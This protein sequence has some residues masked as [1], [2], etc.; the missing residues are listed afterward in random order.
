M[1]SGRFP[2]SPSAAAGPHLRASGTAN[3]APKCG[4]PTAGSALRRI[5]TR[6]ETPASGRPCSRSTRTR[7]L[8][9]APEVFDVVV[10]VDAFPYSGRDDPC[11]RY[12]A[13][14][15]K[16]GGVLGIAGA[17]LMQEIEGPVP[18]HLRDRCEP[19]LWCLSS[20]VWWRRHWKR[21][22]FV[23]TGDI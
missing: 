11:L 16:S 23:E 10:S 17:G 12:A 1:N 19:G 21:T 6:F 3:S 14:F 8:P 22:G 7:A 2:R 13:R 20:G 18:D 5:H 9:C 4:P 15:L